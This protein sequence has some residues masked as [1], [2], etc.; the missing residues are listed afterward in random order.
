ME[1][2]LSE[3]AIRRRMRCIITSSRGISD[4]DVCL[5]AIKSVLLLT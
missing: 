5:D 4:E 2:T 3:K 1:V